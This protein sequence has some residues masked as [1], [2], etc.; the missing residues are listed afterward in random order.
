MANKLK[1]LGKVIFPIFV[2]AFFF[3]S[4]EKKYIYTYKSIHLCTKQQR[5]VVL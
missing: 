2:N 1:L 5:K 3:C 4:F